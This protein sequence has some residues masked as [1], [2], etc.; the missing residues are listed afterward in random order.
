M[1]FDQKKKKKVTTGKEA[2]DNNRADGKPKV[3]EL[4]EIPNEEELEEI[5]SCFIP[6]V[7][8]PDRDDYIHTI[9]RQRQ[10]ETER[11]TDREKDTSK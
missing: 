5:S 4:E 6:L 1:C 11:Q 2:C 10:L 8:G 9:H 7:I 3:V